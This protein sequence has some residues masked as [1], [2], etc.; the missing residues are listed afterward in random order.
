MKSIYYGFYAYWY[1]FVR[2]SQTIKKE[3]PHLWVVRLDLN[4]YTGELD[5][6]LKNPSFNN[7]NSD[8][9]INFLSEDLLKFNNNPFQEK[10]FKNSLKQSGGIVLLF[11][12][13]DEISPSYD[14]IVIT[15]ET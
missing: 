12:G 13:F 10:L 3:Q 8:E 11:D 2:L 6:E 7:H 15:G 1:F 14:D 9:T 5:K 4:N